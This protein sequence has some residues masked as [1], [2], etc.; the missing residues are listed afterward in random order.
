MNRKIVLSQYFLLSGMVTGLVFLA[1]SCSHNT[2]TT[3]SVMNKT[4][5]RIYETMPGY[6]IS[7]LTH[8]KVLSLFS[9]DE[10]NVLGT[11][12]WTFDVNVPVV[13]SVMRDSRQKTIPFWLTI[14]GFRKTNLAIKNDQTMYEVW[15]KSFR[16]GKVGLGVNG[17]DNDGL[18]YFASVGPG[19][20]GESLIL[21]NFSPANQFVGTLDNG[22]FTYHDWDELVL[23]EVPE[24]MIGQK[25][26]TTVRG[27]NTESHLVNA[28]RKT[29]FP[30][31]S[32][33]D[34]MVLTWS[35]DPS[36][37]VNLQWRTD[38]TIKTG[39][40][41]FRESGTHRTDSVTAVKVLLEDRMLMNDRLVHH[42]NARME[43][44]KPGTMYQY[45]INSANWPDLQTFSTA[46]QDNSFSF[47]WFGDTHHSPKS[48]E[49]LN[50]AFHA[51][52]DAAFFS[53]AGDLVSDGLHRNQWDEL[54]EFSKEVACR[55]PFMA[56]PGNHDNRAGLGA[57]TFRDLF[58]FPENGPEGVEKEQTY[59]FTYKNCLFLMLDATSPI[60]AQ[61]A[62]IDQQLAQSGAT[63]KIALF[64]FPPYNWEEPYLDI[65]HAWVPVFDKYHVDLVFSGHTHYYMRSKP[66]RDGKVVPSCS[67]GTVY[68]ISIAIPRRGNL[69]DEP[70]AEVQSTEGQLYQYVRID[71][72]TLSFQSVNSENKPID[73]FTIQ[74]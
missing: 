56:V 17:F 63:W 60:D 2:E 68:V 9:K 55:I 73:F 37:S 10:L 21:S 46:A 70:Y 36:T 52:P 72:N 61:S 4:I 34:Q 14:N 59:S 12:H 8:E 24:E 43:G 64:H 5:S 66:L 19:E 33:P 25:L 54:F 57:R 41:V 51:H 50:R 45:K 11:K 62:W 26:L 28:F 49:N 39:M 30:S 27:R 65:Q 58:S 74:K 13:V 16:K 18:H 15:Q 31:S 67:E 42:F 48:G 6:E 22:A 71:G 20:E 1:T 69:P 35:S 29:L 53:I 44:L 32:H 40:V 38:T 23:S 47:L 3:Q 7:G